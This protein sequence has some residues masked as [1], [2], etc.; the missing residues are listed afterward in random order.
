MELGGQATSNSSDSTGGMHWT[1][2]QDGKLNFNCYRRN[3]SSS[4]DDFAFASG[5]LNLAALQFGYSNAAT[6][7]EK[8]G[9]PAVIFGIFQTLVLYSIFRRLK[10][11]ESEK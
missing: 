3:G 5:D 2:K 11:K 1:V 10:N 6:L 4:G 9:I 8:Y 7:Q